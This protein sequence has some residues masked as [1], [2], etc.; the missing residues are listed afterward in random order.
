MQY[1]TTFTNASLGNESQKPDQVVLSLPNKS[2]DNI[3]QLSEE[4]CLIVPTL[5]FGMYNKLIHKN[6]EFVD[7]CIILNLT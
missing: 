7:E 2:E 4:N 3:P 5:S 6:M 1:E